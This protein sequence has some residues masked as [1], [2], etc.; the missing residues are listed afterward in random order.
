MYLCRVNVKKSIIVSAPSGAGKT[1]LVRHLLAV[2]PEKLQFSISATTRNPRGNEQNGIDYFFLSTAEF[3]AKI[4]QNAFVEYEEVYASCFYGTLKSQLE[5]IWAL[6]KIVVFD[7][8]VKGGMHLKSIFKTQALSIFIA[9]P[10]IEELKK[11]LVSRQTDSLQSITA[12]VSKARHEMAFAK[13]FD[14][15]ITNDELQLACTQLTDCV[16]QFIML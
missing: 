11:R 1:T 6:D 14:I 7:V 3:K 2:M 15:Q 4:K 13:N 16:Q 12:R 9:P 8:D 5:D 10:S